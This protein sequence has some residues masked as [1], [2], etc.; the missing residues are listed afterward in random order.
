MEK[1]VEDVYSKDILDYFLRVF[2]LDDS[3][4]VLS[5]F[6]NYVYEVMKDNHPYILRVTHSSHR[7]EQEIL[8]ELDWINYL[9]SQH[10]NVPTIYKSSNETYIE[11]KIAKDHT[12]FFACLFSKV[13][14]KALR[15]TDELFNEDLFEKWGRET[16]KMHRVTVN[17]HPKQ[18]LR[19]FWYEDDLFEVDKY[20]DN[21]IVVARTQEIV[22]ALHSLPKE[23]FGLIHNDIHYGNFFFNG[24]SIS[25]FDFDD[26]CYFWHV[27]DIAIPLYYTCSALFT[28]L[29][30]MKE[31][32][33]FT[34]TFLT[35]FM[36][37]YTL[38]K[39]P[40]KDWEKLLP[41]FLKVRD[42][43]LYAAL[44]KKI[45]PEDR[46]ER[47]QRRMEEIRERIEKKMPIVSYN[48]EGAV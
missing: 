15:V 1:V 40:P 28:N 43:T 46:D 3:Y 6:E 41:L 16:A 2:K 24:E 20:I 33:S 13:Q 8:G 17:Y 29:T 22:K 23:D 19:K 34:A 35:A 25:I 36:K 7:S 45:A 4:K 18:K 10:V 21:D 38:E 32:N 31:K 42:I 30:S 39:E 5:G 14:G 11:K 9:N 37:G 48:G 12:I 27:S 44:H 26:A 47:L